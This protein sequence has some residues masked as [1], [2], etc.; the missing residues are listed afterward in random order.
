MKSISQLIYIQARIAN[1]GWIENDLLDL[2]GLFI[3]EELICS[4][5]AQN[6]VYNIYMLAE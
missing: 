5:A 1:Y 4:I 2:K 6:D 3:L